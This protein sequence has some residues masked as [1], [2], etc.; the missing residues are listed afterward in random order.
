MPSSGMLRRVAHEITDVSGES[1]SSIITI[2]SVRRLLV[3]A[4]VFPSSQIF[5]FLTMEA[6]GSTE[7]SVLA[8]VTQHNIPEDGILHSHLCKNLKSYIKLEMFHV[9][10]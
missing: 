3:T 6:K 8:R 5:V 10:C 2:R 7:T 1:S 4:N 9:T